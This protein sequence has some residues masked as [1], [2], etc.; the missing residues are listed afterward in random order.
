[1]TFGCDHGGRGQ[2]VTE[3]GDYF[4]TMKWNQGPGND[5]PHLASNIIKSKVSSSIAHLYQRPRVWLEGF[6]SSGWQTSGAD[7][8]DAVFRNFGLGHNLLSL[9]GLYYSTHGS[10]WEWA[11]PCNHYHMPY[12]SQMGTLLECTRRLSYVLSQGVHRCDAAVIY[13]VAAVEADEEQGKQAVA[14]AF[15]MGRTLYRGGIDFDFIDFESVER[16]GTKNGKL[17]VAR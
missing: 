16:A 5:Q 8:A 15:E 10:M 9:H 11:P 14:A 3:F 6:Y 13:P 4:R 2:D 12:W 17:C 7:V 1:M